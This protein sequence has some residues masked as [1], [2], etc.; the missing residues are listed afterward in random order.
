MWESFRDC[1][2]VQYPGAWRWITEFVGPRECILLFNETEDEEMFSVSSGS[3][4]GELLEE[5]YGFEF[6]VTDRD[7]AYLIC[8]NHHDFLICCGTAKTW[9]LARIE[10]LEGGRG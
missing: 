3:A 9:L 8:F 1:A 6:Y 4:L 7:V 10:E 2:S 5:T